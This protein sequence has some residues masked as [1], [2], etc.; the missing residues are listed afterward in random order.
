MKIAWWTASC[1]RTV[2]LKIV[3]PETRAAGIQ[4]QGCGNLHATDEAASSRANC[5]AAMARCRAGLLRWSA[6]RVSWGTAALSRWR[7]SLEAFV[8][9]CSPGA[10]SSGR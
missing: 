8:Q 3:Q 7:R 5:R 10:I 9:W 1:R 2:K 4:I 6:L